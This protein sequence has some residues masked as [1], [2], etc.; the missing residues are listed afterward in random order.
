MFISLIRQ[1][2]VRNGGW[3]EFTILRDMLSAETVAA[4]G[5]SNQAIKT[6]IEIGGADFGGCAAS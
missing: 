3:N 6:G 2:Q 5:L 1:K 4:I